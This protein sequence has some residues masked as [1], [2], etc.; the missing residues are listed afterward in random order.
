[1][2]DQTMDLIAKS[3]CINKWENKAGVKLTDNFFYII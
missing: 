2:Q 3:P 1:M